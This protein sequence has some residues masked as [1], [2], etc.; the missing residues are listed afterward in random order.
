MMRSCYEK[1]LIDCINCMD[2]HILIHAQNVE[3]PNS[4]NYSRGVEAY[5]NDNIK[6]A[7]EI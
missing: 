6:E 7:L 4:Y 3:R 5:R 2:C 1:H